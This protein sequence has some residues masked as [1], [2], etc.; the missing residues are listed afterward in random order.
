MVGEDGLDG[1]SLVVSMVRVWTAERLDDGRTDGPRTAAP[2]GSLHER[3]NGVYG[4]DVGCG[5][6]GGGER[7]SWWLD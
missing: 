2:D 4:E 7:R 1:G 5:R 3:A 6:E